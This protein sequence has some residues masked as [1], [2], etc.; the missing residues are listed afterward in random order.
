MARKMVS[1][2]CTACFGGSVTCW[3]CGGPGVIYGF[4]RYEEECNACGGTG[5]TTCEVCG[6]TYTVWE[7]EDDPE[8]NFT[9]SSVNSHISSN[10]KNRYTD[11]YRSS[12]K[13]NA[14]KAK[15]GV[16][17]WGVVV[18]AFIVWVLLNS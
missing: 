4:N 15:G 11:T 2:T 18:V 10:R 6:G 9:S 7:F 13:K 17:F 12:S 8:D 16:S 5:Q 1:K 3:K 14:K